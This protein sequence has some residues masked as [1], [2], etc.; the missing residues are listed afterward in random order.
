MNPCLAD[1]L[2][3]VRNRCCR[4]WL[5]CAHR[6]STAAGPL[7]AAID[8]IAKSKTVK[9]AAAYFFFRRDFFAPF[10]AAPFAFDFL[11]FAM[12]PS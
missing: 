2:C 7:D 5:R 8:I 6:P 11:F 1:A 3:V 10:F 9:W 12:L 4:K